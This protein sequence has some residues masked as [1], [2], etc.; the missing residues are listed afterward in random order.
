MISTSFKFRT[1]TYEK[2]SIGVERKTFVLSDEIPIIKVENVYA[3]EYYE[4]EEHGHKPTLRLKINSL[5]YNNEQE[6]VYMDEI[7]SII[8]AQN[9][10]IDEMILVCERKIGNG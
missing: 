2:D 7:Y 3:N 8:R 5:N 9:S 6:L 10:K 1:I 4:A